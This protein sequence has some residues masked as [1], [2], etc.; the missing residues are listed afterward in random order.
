MT[1]IPSNQARI[2]VTSMLQMRRS[3]FMK[4]LWKSIGLALFVSL[5][6]WSQ[7]A[8]PL[9]VTHFANQ[10]NFTWSVTN[11]DGRNT[12]IFVR[13]H[14][15]ANIGWAATT[16]VVI[17][18]TIPSGQYRQQFIVQIA[19]STVLVQ[20]SQSAAHASAPDRRLVVNQPNSGDMTT[21]SGAC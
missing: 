17:I 16:H 5:T 8:P 2:T 9:Y 7:P 10:S 12:T 14:T 20:N 11:A 1:G 15:T 21:C 3:Y 19:N 13:P 4:T 6:A 18:G